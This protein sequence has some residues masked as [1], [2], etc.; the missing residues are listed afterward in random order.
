MLPSSHV[1]ADKD[2]P[3][4]MSLY[5]AIVSRTLLISQAVFSQVLQGM[6]AR[7]AAFEQ[8]LD[9][10][11]A[12]MPCVVNREKKK[13]LG[14]ALASLLTAQN[15]VVYER[16]PTIVKRLCETLNDIMKEDDDTGVLAE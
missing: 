12:R 16:T 4:V 5:L 15:E 13:L 11:L 10:W 2:Y 14:L 9:V 1:S 8:I 7:G 6:S 3:M